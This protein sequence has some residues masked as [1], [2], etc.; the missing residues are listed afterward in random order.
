MDDSVP[1]PRSLEE[2][3]EA[4][5][6]DPM[7]YTNGSTYRFQ[8]GDILAGKY[9]VERVLG[10]G[11]MGI[12]LA[13]EHLQLRQPVAI[14]LL[15]PSVSADPDTIA[16]FAREAQAA[17]RIQSEHVARVIDV[18]ALED[19]SPYMVMEFL[20][21]QDLGKVLSQR[22][23]LPLEEAVGYLLQS[24]E[25][26]AEAHAA[27]IVHRDLK[28]SNLFVCQ[29]PGG[30]ITI[31]VL[32]FGISKAQP[33]AQ[34]VDPALTRTGAVMGSPLYMSPEQMVSAKYVDARTDIW[35]LGVTLF[36]LLCGR[37]PFGGE[38]MTELIAAV[39][40]TEPISVRDLRPDLPPSIAT[41]LRGALE[42]DPRRR[43]ASVAEFA[44]AIAPFGPRHAAMIVE[45]ITYALG[46]ARP[47]AIPV[48][49]VSGA[50][51][52]ALD[53]TA[54]AVTGPRGPGATTAKPVS[55]DS[56]RDAPRA[57]G[58]LR[59]G[60][61]LVVV[62]GVLLAGAG[63][64]AALRHK[65]RETPTTASA[66]ASSPPVAAS[67]P[68]L[69]ASIVPAAAPSLPPSPPPEL[70]PAPTEVPATVSS[71]RPHKASTPRPASPVPPATP[72]GHPAQ[73]SS[74]P[75]PASAPS[76]HVEQYLDAD[77]ETRFR[78]ECP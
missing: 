51:V 22:G 70:A 27:G 76:C 24:C 38:S 41:A 8:K 50:A 33:S 37:T 68:V 21:G 10:A 59:P 16:R 9:R 72:A 34:A 43:Y 55:S 36:E 52:I 11:G 18:A 1:G 48:T 58:A 26:V 73:S 17:A 46:S 57:S 29:R 78:R 14:K 12:V 49:P 28:P 25:G 61:V 53:A 77:G 42:K 40:Q 67:T 56:Q 74:A 30:R 44:A 32:D 31:K 54:E 69:P 6:R 62:A 45:R 66:E 13:A 23:P 39:L 15:L 71:A 64:A 4:R 63:G 19:G 5:G 47:A 20:E 35:S 75:A 3:E 7:T 65:G 2:E 60:R